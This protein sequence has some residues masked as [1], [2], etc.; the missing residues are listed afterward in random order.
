MTTLSLQVLANSTHETT[1]V[2][3]R[4]VVLAFVGA[5]VTHKLVAA[6]AGTARCVA[7]V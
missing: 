6:V 3:A 1:V 7:Q 4:S 2:A 5:H